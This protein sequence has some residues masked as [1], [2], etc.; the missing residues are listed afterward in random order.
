MTSTKVSFPF[1]KEK[2]VPSFIHKVAVAVL[3]NKRKAGA[4]TKTRGDVAGGGTKPW[5]QKGT[6]RA[7]A[8]STRSPLWR[9]G[10]I[11]FGPRNIRSYK[12]SVTKNERRRA[13]FQVFSEKLKR[14]QII[15]VSDFAKGETKT[16]KM[17]Q[18]LKKLGAEGRILILLDTPDT[19][20][21]RATSNIQGVSV[22]LIKDAGVLDLLS[23]D[24]VILTK[25][26]TA[27]L[28]DIY[29]AHS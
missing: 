14:N 5:R 17:V 12:K 24:H 8:G 9:G 28:K 19:S 10:G 29:E 22:K 27:L 16:K 26:A 7:R 20:V 23:C 2:V 21:E 3:S 18:T 15:V 11:T 13:Y 1:A 6:G 25:K 4:H